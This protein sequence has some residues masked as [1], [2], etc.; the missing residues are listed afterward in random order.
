M[1][2]PFVGTLNGIFF[3]AL[4]GDIHLNNKSFLFGL[5]GWLC[6]NIQPFFCYNQY[7]ILLYYLFGRDGEISSNSNCH[8]FNRLSP[9]S[10]TPFSCEL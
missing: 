2:N 10:D 1:N 7:K 5:E 4:N 8:A 9:F 3:R 6:L